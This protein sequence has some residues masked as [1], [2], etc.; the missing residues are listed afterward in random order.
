MTIR[1]IQ[2]SGP[3]AEPI[4]LTEAKIHLRLA[5][6]AEDAVDNCGHHDPILA[7]VIAGARM[8]AEAVQWRAL[9]L[10]VFDLYL[11]AWPMFGE[12]EIPFPPLRAVES[13]SYTDTTGAVATV[14]AEDYSV[15]L[16]SVY[17]RVILGDGKSWPSVE[18]AAANPIKIRFKAGYAV[19]FTSN[20]TTDTIDA[21]NH[22]FVDGEAVRLSVSGGNLPGGLSERK[23]YFVRDV[24]G[25]TLKLAATEGG[26]AIDLTSAGTGTMFIGEIPKNTII[27]MLLSITD[28]FEGRNDSEQVIAQ[29]LAYDTARRL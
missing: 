2:H 23:D 26:A 9:V 6:D 27:A 28:R 11:D 16:A 17:G 7:P 29:W 10:Q 5:V 3:T 18:L 8:Q 21:P 25:D 15:D 4:H 24:A 20:A 13:I 12:F 14:P 19:P 1:T 22:P